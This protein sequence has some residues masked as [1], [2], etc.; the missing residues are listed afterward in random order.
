MCACVRA[1]VCVCV[2]RASAC[3]DYVLVLCALLCSVQCTRFWKISGRKKTLV[4]AVVPCALFSANEGRRV[5]VM[6]VSRG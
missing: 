5:P 1:R 4:I 6:L 2:A 3:F